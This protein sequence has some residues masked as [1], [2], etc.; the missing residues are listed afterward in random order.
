MLPL[1]H[2]EAFTLFKMKLINKIQ[3]LFISCFNRHFHYS[4]IISTVE[5][6]YNGMVYNLSTADDETYV[7][8]TFVV[9]NCRS[10]TAPK[11]SPE[12]DIF[13]EGATRASKGA[14]GGKQV[15]A[16]TTYYDWLKRQPASYQDEVLGKTKGLIFRN[17]GLTPEQFRAITVDDLGRP[18]TLE[19]MAAMDKRVA[20]YLGK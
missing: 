19:E 10:S 13:D 3:N 1:Y 18:L 11:L 20:T 2:A 16:D 9:H 5:S 7:A 17:S 12:F 15:A 8:N 4:T 6:E 14:D